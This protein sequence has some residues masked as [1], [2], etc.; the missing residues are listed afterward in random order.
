M[1]KKNISITEQ[2]WQKI[3]KILKDDE[4]TEQRDG[5][6]Y[7]NGEFATNFGKDGEIIHVSWNNYPDEE[8]WQDLFGREHNE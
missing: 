3:I 5:A 2:T 7:F 4:W 6:V 8:E 1:K